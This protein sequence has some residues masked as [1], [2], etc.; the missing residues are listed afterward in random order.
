MQTKTDKTRPNANRRTVLTSGVAF[1]G[2]FACANSKIS[3]EATMFNV[4]NKIVCAE[5]ARENVASIISE[6]AKAMPGCKLYSISLDREN[7]NLIWVY[8]LWESERRHTDSVSLQ[9][10]QEAMA[11]A[12][13]HITGAESVAVSD[14]YAVF[15]RKL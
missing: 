8:E 2:A 12:R 6:G 1:F 10:V 13:P 11:K 9:S 15:S 5:G 7:E 4:L 3:G 14:A